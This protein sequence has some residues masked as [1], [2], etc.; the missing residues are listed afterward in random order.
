MA[1]ANWTTVICAMGL[2]AIVE[3][4]AGCVD[5][6]RRRQADGAAD[7]RAIDDALVADALDPD[8]SEL[9]A[10][11]ADTRAP[12]SDAGAPNSDARDGG[13]ADG[14]ACAADAGACDGACV[15]L[16]Y[17]M[18]NCGA[19]GQVCS[20]TNHRVA[21]CQRGS[22]AI[23]GC[24][25]GYGDCDGHSINGCETA[26]NTPLNCGACGLRGVSE[27]CNGVD[28]NCNGVTDENCPGSVRVELRAPVLPNALIPRSIAWVTGSG[29]VA[30]VD[31]VLCPGGYVLRGVSV[32]RS[33]ARSDLLGTVRLR[34]AQVLLTARPL[35]L[36]LGADEDGDG[37][38]LP[39]GGW[40]SWAPEGA[41]GVCPAGQI[42]TAVDSRWRNAGGPAI[43]EGLVQLGVRCGTLAIDPISGAVTVNAAAALPSWT[44]ALAATADSFAVTGGFCAASPL[45]GLHLNVVAPA[46]VVLQF[47]EYCS[48]ISI[49][50]P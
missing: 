47:A 39:A 14:D 12:P 18:M 41:G 13:G 6:P 45:A 11:G 19:C 34:C 28:D 44:T 5:V 10:L 7:S 48:N 31:S 35:A 29:E 36:R 40:A 33:A 1:Y 9:D 21:S 2:G 16:A 20:A 26:I 38:P 23:G 25:S 46:G 3:A 22:C 37:R 49:T 24:E 27:T 42:V 17:D 50:F 8:A 32:S 15:D 43:G 4:A 30:S